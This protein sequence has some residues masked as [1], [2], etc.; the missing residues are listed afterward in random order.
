ML[1]NVTQA[2]DAVSTSQRFDLSRLS[3]WGFWAGALLFGA[4]TVLSA[5]LP[6]WPT[7]PK[8]G[9]A[10]VMYILCVSVLGFFTWFY[11]HMIR[12]IRCSRLLWTPRASGWPMRR[13]RKRS[14]RGNPLP[15]SS[16][17]TCG[18][19]SPY[20]QARQDPHRPRICTGR[21]RPPPQRWSSSGQVWPP[22][23]ATTEDSRREFGCVRRLLL[24]SK[25]MTH[26]LVALSALVAFAALGAY[27]GA[28]G[29]DVGP[30]R[31][32]CHT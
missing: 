22:G 28:L 27:V 30:V 25:G 15:A 31:K 23:S 12:R 16:R 2:N 20:R 18:G 29:A 13:R 9:G 32:S 6:F 8:T 3:R 21:F 4:F 11:I 19:G 17:T 24:H 26:H 5:S 1:Q 10:I 7:A 14:F